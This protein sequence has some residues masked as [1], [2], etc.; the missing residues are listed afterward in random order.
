MQH[1]SEMINT[2][3]E[4]VESA[5]MYI[6][7]GNQSMKDAIDAQK[8]ARKCWCCLIFCVIIAIIATVSGVGAF[9]SVKGK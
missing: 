3:E 6:K 8:K 5:T 4:N 7:K 2:I 1:Q 9:F